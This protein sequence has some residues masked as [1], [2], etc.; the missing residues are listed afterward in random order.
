MVHVMSCIINTKSL[1]NFC[2]T[3]A[4]YLN[5]PEMIIS[6]IKYEARSVTILIMW[7]P[8]NSVSYNVSSKPKMAMIDLHVMTSSV[9]FS[10][11]YNVHY[12]VSIVATS[13]CGRNSTATELYYGE[14]LLLEYNMH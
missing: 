2:S 3:I 7:M 13:M 8:Q 10:I 9:Q 1:F 5:R 11:S 6:D 12:N 14:L 4:D